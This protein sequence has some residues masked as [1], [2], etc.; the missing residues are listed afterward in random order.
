MPAAHAGAPAEKD[1]PDQVSSFDLVV[2]GA[3][4]GGLAAAV[5][6]AEAGMR[7]CLIDDNPAPGGQ[8]WRSGYGLGKKSGAAGKWFARLEQRRIAIRQGWRAVW[9][10]RSS[11]GMRLLRVEKDGRC[12]DLACNSLVLA[13]GAR[14][15][16]LPFPGWTLPGVYG[17]GGLQAFVK[18][19]L[20]LEGKRV[21]V[22]GTGPLLLAVAHGL[23]SAGARVLAVVEQA[24]A[25]RLARFSLGLLSGQP[26]KLTEGAAYA[27]RLRGIPYYTGSWITHALGDGRLRAVRVAHGSRLREI[28]TDMLAVGY[29]LVASTELAQLLGCAVDAGPQGTGNL[30]RVDEMQQ[31]SLPGIYCVGEATGIGGVDKAIV[32]GRIAGHAAGGQMERARAW[33]AARDR[34]R[35]FVRLLDATFALRPELRGLAEDATTVCRCEDVAHDALKACRSWRE[36]KLHTRCGMGPCQGR[37]CGAAAGFLYGWSVPAPRPPLFP[38][39]VGVLASV[40]GA[41]ATSGVSL[42]RDSPVPVSKENSG[43]QRRTAP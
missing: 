10:G 34:Q 18:S 4:P 38:V 36:A 42:L 9:G 35:R 39:E 13:T 40:Q 28:E 16:F 33:T 6:G 27:W 29:H 15:L 32:E 11:S 26:G 30:V 21:V 23:R 19:G 31:T 25:E 14:E 24:P 41:D 2:V 17:A 8:I 7:V 37:I 3:G 22:A 5:T 12:E 20:E 43:E 1:A